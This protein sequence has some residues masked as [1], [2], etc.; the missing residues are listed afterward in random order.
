MSSVPDNKITKE[1]IESIRK[2]LTFEIK[3]NIS[4]WAKGR[5]WFVAI[6]VGAVTVFGVRGVV[7]QVFDDEIGDIRDESRDIV[8]EA[9]VA[10][11]LADAAARNAKKASEEARTEIDTL[12][13]ALVGLKKTA[14]DTGEELAELQNK[15]SESKFTEDKS[16]KSTIAWVWPD[17]VDKAPNQ[18]NVTA[19]RGW[20][21]KS[22]GDLPI[23]KFI[24]HPDL[25]NYREKAIEELLSNRVFKMTDVPEEKLDQVIDGYKL[26]N[27][28]NIEKVKQPDGKWTVTAT[29]SG[30]LPG[31][32]TTPPP[33]GD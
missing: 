11:G 4:K 14:K 9:K 22:I 28:T 15:L 17:G 8:I 24:D 27:P 30:G 33:E 18:D 3:E 26:D 25:K 31:N 23:Q 12:R 21:D 5:F 13:T 1:E 2:E 6:L 16:S 19:L 32:S 29:F 7:K 10:V 20:I